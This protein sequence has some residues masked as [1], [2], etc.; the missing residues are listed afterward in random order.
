M[1]YGIDD[2]EEAVKIKRLRNA[3]DEGEAS[4]FI[5]DYDFDEHLKELKS[6]YYSK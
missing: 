5:S 4:G 3:F 2:D 1:L 6:K